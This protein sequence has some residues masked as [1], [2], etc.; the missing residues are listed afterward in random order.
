M[1]TSEKWAV[2]SKETGISYRYYDSK[3]EAEKVA[4]EMSDYHQKAYVA[5]KVSDLY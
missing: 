4:R 5:V 1:K 2:V 3:R